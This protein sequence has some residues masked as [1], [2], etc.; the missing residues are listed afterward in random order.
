MVFAT[1]IRDND[2]I[3]DKNLNPFRPSSLAEFNVV[4][5]SYHD[6]AKD[7]RI[8]AAIHKWFQNEIH[9]ELAEDEIFKDVFNIE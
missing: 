4:L 5:N 1:E 2:R 8:L 7:L 3:V 9:K 6:G